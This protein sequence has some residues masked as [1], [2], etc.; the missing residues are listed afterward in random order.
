[1]PEYVGDLLQGA[2]FLQKL[3]GNAMPKDVRPGM[4]PTTSTVCRLDRGMDHSDPYR[5]IEGRDV[6]N[7]DGPICGGWPLGAQVFGDRATSLERKREDVGAPALSLCYPYR[8]RVP[9]NVVQRNVDDLAGAQT[10]IRKASNNS[11]GAPRRGERFIERSKELFHFAL[12]EHDWK[13]C[14]P[15]VSFTPARGRPALR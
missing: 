13:R 6:A 4:C 3:A 15:P 11:I 5:N 12:G 10:Q 1:M 9:I 7:K 2:S 8:P 14:Q